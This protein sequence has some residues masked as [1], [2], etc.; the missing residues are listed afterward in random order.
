M[1][2]PANKDWGS[3]SLDLSNATVFLWDIS[4]GFYS[5]EEG[6]ANKDTSSGAYPLVQFSR[7][8]L[9]LQLPHS[10]QAVLSIHQDTPPLT[11]TAAITS[12][13]LPNVAVLTLALGIL[14]DFVVKGAGLQPNG[15]DA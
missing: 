3:V 6:Q 11:P 9:I 13:D 2:M 4:S 7:P 12:N 14:Q 8:S 1:F 15:G 5:T 10:L